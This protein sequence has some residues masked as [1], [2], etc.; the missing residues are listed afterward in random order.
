M[1]RAVSGGVPGCLAGRAFFN[2]DHRGRV[3]KCVEFRG[4]AD[5]L[6]ALPA[7]AASVIRPKLRA[8]HAANDCQSCWYA[9]RVEIESLYTVRGL[10]GGLRTLV[11]A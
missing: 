2:V 11:T 1:G 5:R 3:S 4:A 6:G 9:S 8:A 7:D 10:L